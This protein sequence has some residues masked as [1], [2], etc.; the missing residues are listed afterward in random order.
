MKY[1]EYK[2]HRT[3]G[4]KDFPVAFYDVSSHHPRYQMP[5]HWHEEY[6]I[7]HIISGS[8]HLS[9][10]Q[11]EYLLSPGDNALIE[12][13]FLHGGIPE[14]CHYQCIVFDLE[15]L[16][17]SE[18]WASDIREALY[19]DSPGPHFPVLVDSCSPVAVPAILSLCQALKTQP[20]GYRLT[21]I[22]SLYQLMGSLLTIEKHGA[23]PAQTPAAQ[24]SVFDTSTPLPLNLE[25]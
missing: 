17:A 21:V 6:E 14:D 11:K 12:G 4:S 22:G 9:V 7:I 19:Q 2:E 25:G 8:F 20:Q 13:G 18:I 15:H 10:N 3:H 1:I 24:K 23:V 5:F 16:L